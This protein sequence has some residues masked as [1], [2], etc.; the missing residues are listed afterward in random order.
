MPRSLA[1]NRI[2]ST[3]KYAIQDFKTSL[4]FAG[5]G[6][7]SSTAIPGT[8]AGFTFAAWI[9]INSFNGP[10]GTPFV[11]GNATSLTDMAGMQLN[12]SSISAS[13]NNGSSLN[14]SSDGSQLTSGRWVHVVFTYDGATTVKL[15][16]NGVQQSGTAGATAVSAASFELARRNDGNRRALISLAQVL[17]YTRPINPIEVSNLYTAGVIP[18]SPYRYLPLGEGAG[19]TAIDMS[20]NAVN[21]TISNGVYGYDTPTTKR[22]LVGGSLADNGDL[23]FIPG[24]ITSNTTTSSRWVDGSAGGS[25]SN[26]L[27]KYGIVF[28][29]G[30]GSVGFDTTNP[31]NAKP[32]IILAANAGSRGA[33]IYGNPSN[34]SASAGHQLIPVSP[35]TSYTLSYYIKT[36]ANVAVNSACGGRIEYS[37]SLSA[38][39]ETL[40]S[41]KFSANTGWTQVVETFTTAS[42]TQYLL[43]QARQDVAPAVTATMWWGDIRLTPTVNTSRN[44]AI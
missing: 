19:T 39:A 36:D 24:V 27:F 28:F 11:F 38:G 20:G 3:N 10:A 43:L 14:V 4:M 44:L 12:S 15:W 13:F 26:N 9:K 22:K 29:T 23:S 6:G 16:V 32:S 37:G 35:N 8:A 42:T 21:G 17:A 34:G 18:S 5:T 25:I 2:G 30:S 41:T 33:V 31:I 40:S 1:S 7:I